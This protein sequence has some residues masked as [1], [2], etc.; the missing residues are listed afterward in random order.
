MQI[1]FRRCGVGPENLN[2]NKIPSD[3][4]TSGLW[5]TFSVA[6]AIAEVLRGWSLDHRD[7][8]HLGT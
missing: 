3:A 8:Y 4:N 1:L 6:R 7:Q 5:I 2:F